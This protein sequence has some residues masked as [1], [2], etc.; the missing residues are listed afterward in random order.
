[1]PFGG[2]VSDVLSSN[3]NT[4]VAIYNSD[5]PELPDD[6][7]IVKEWEEQMREWP[8]LRDTMHMVL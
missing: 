6:D 7:P 1:M 5:E 2:L 8:V 4:E 3:P